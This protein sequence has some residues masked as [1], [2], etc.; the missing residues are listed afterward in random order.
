MSTM[1]AAV[2]VSAYYT[3]INLSINITVIEHKVS[4]FRLIMLIT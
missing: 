2:Q 1:N 3:I 4:T